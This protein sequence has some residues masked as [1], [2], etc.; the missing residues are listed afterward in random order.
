MLERLLEEH[1][2]TY[3]E[4]EPAALAKV[5]DPEDVE[6][7]TRVVRLA[8]T[9]R[10]LRKNGMAPL[11]VGGEVV[12]EDGEKCMR[13]LGLPPEEVS[14]VQAIEGMNLELYLGIRGQYGTVLGLR[15]EEGAFRR[16]QAACRSKKA[17]TGLRGQPEAVQRRFLEVRL[18]GFPLLAK[19]TR[20]RTSGK[21]MRH[22]ATRFSAY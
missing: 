4:L 2:V 6:G 15:L 10:E 16:L 1:G 19:L 14:A 17:T 9:N 22:R 12:E 5:R 20:T 8:A 13:L 21:A 18:L 11:L 3:A 7:L